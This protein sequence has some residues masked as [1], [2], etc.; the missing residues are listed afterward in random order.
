MSIIDIEEA[1]P[2]NTLIRDT[3]LSDDL[4]Q[5]N[6]DLDLS[7]HQEEESR[8]DY[9]DDI[10]I[11]DV[12]THSISSSVHESITAKT[13]R[14]KH[15][16]HRI[17]R[18]LAKAHSSSND[19]S[20]ILSSGGNGEAA[21]NIVSPDVRPD[22][23]RASR[24]RPASAPASMSISSSTSGIMTVKTHDESL[25]GHSHVS[26]MRKLRRKVTIKF[27]N[28]NAR[29]QIRATTDKSICGNDQT[30]GEGESIS[31]SIS[32][33]HSAP[34]KSLDSI[35][36]GFQNVCIREYE[37]VPG[38]SPSTS[39]GP[40]LELGWRHGEQ[41]VVDFEK[42]ENIREGNRR[43]N[44]QMRMPK[45]VRKDLLLLHGSTKKMIRQA[46][47]KAQKSW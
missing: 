14:S 11:G 3:N 15:W 12:S 42:Y 4:E 33:F 16:A 21:A 22:I 20:S 25:H 38:C 44:M 28:P 30:G 43:S 19:T 47:K 17:R 35:S 40:P 46:S 8:G 24:P 41:R 45:A 26:K 34:T 29:T 31:E 32:S 18:R 36:I 10:S 13:E 9:S 37:V 7:Y 1:G 27:K 39:S 2:S 5:L 23:T 6:L